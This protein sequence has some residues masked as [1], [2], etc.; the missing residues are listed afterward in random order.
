MTI[1]AYGPTRP[2]RAWRPVNTRDEGW[3]WLRRVHRRRV[4]LDLPGAPG[5]FWEY[6]K[7]GSFQ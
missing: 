6:F 2:W 4:Y 1:T 5:P 3:T 7:Q